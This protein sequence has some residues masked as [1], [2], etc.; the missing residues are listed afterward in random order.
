L[1]V[2]PVFTDAGPAMLSVNRLVIA[3]GSAVLLLASATLCAVTV[4]AAGDGRMPGAV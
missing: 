2:A 4:T 3:I 1:A